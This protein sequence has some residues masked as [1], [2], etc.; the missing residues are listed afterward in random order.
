MCAYFLLVVIQTISLL[1]VLFSEH[2]I[3]KMK[4]C[5]AIFIALFGVSTLLTGANAAGLPCDDFQGRH[6]AIIN[7]T[8]I[9]ITVYQ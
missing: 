8:P 7:V 6:Y 9:L 3:K 2:G 4:L 1:S 5:A